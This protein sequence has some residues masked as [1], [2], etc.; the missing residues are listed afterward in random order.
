M[1]CVHHEITP[2]LLQESQE[3]DHTDVL[4]TMA[5]HQLTAINKMKRWAQS[6]LQL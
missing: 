2:L 6:T 5:S 1:S 4:N 3:N